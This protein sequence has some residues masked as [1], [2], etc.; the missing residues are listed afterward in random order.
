MNIKPTTSSNLRIEGGLQK[1]GIFKKSNSDQCLITIITVVYN[2]VGVIESTINNLLSQTYANVEYIVVDGGSI[3][4]TLDVICSYEDKIDYFISEKDHGIY[5]AMNKALNKA[6]GEWVYFLNCGDVFYDDN[7]LSLVNEHLSGDEPIVHFNCSVKDNEGN[8]VNVRRFPSLPE[9]L[10][11]WPC[12]QHQ[13]VFCRR[14]ILK[15]LGGFDISLKLLADYD[16]F[17]RAY[18]RGAS[19]KTF[20]E[21]KISVYNSEGVSADP[22]NIS[23][24]RREVKTIQLNNFGK[25]N[26]SLQIQLYFKTLIVKLPF[27]NFLERFIRGVFFVKR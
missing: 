4:G 10:R 1:K 13:S 8:E 18:L 19:F 7:V 2:N 26:C 15:E 20:P 6:T 11:K 25:F 5:D 17:V 21:F 24:L 12:V 3:D 9:H 22:T 27:S 16:F 14:S 23:L